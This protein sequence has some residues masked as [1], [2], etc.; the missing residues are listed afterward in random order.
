MLH[1]CTIAEQ[2]TQMYLRVPQ[3]F[4]FPSSQSPTSPATPTVLSL[5]FSFLVSSYLFLVIDC[6]CDL[7]PFY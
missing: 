3:V 7:L 6:S 5:F 1:V 2:F 4:R